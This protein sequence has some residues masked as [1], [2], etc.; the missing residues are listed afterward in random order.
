[1]RT[2]SS[3][4][5]WSISA[6]GVVDHDVHAVGGGWRGGRRHPAIV[7]GRHGVAGGRQRRHQGQVPRRG[8]LAAAGDE[9]ERLP[10]AGHVVAERGPVGADLRNGAPRT[11][12]WAPRCGRSGAPRSACSSASGV[13]TPARSAAM[14]TAPAPSSTR[15]ILAAEN[16][17]AER[18]SASL[19]VRT[20]TPCVERD[21][22]RDRARLEVAGQAVGHGRL[23]VDRHDRPRRQTRCSWRARP[24]TRCPTTRTPVP[25]SPRMTPDSSPPPPQGTTTVP[26]LGTCSTSSRATRRLPGDDVGIV[27]GR[28]VAAPVAGSQLE[29]VRLCVAVA[30]AVEHEAQV[31]L[32]ERGDLGRR[33]PV[34]TTTVTWAPSF[35]AA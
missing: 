35:D 13:T 23:D 20:S 12:D 16:A 25:S 31:E 22:D 10:L 5:R 29:R 15:P 18:M 32:L 6:N 34:G 4:P 17:M 33:G 27:V 1:M 3:Q 2:G 26:R 11:G 21:V 19:T 14:P 7:E 28:H 24:R 9:Q 8:G 30:L